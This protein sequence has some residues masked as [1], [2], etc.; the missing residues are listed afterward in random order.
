VLAILALGKN[1]T[2]QAVEG[3]TPNL[4][5]KSIAVGL[6]A[7]SIYSFSD[8]FLKILCGFTLPV[9]EASSP[10]RKEG[11]QGIVPVDGDDGECLF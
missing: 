10:K 1:I 11:E 2:I 8:Y 4:D 5:G 3:T 7:G 9:I 6:V